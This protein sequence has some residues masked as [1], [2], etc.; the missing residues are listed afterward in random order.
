MTQKPRGKVPNVLIRCILRLVVR[1]GFETICRYVALCN[2]ILIFHLVAP[3][4][5]AEDAYADA[6]VPVSQVL[7]DDMKK[8]NVIRAGVP[9]GCERL[10]LIK[11]SYM[12]FDGSIHGGGEIMAMDAAAENVLR[13]FAKLHDIRF[14][15]AKAKL[16]NAYDGNDD[17]SMA[18]N[19]TSAFN[20]RNVAGSSSLSLHAYGLAIDLNPI[21]NP[22]AQR[23]GA[24]LTFS[25]PAGIAYA[26]RLND[27]PGKNVRLGMAEAVIDVFAD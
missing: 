23:S 6:I 9:V 12:G 3:A 19:N 16:V 2:A 20:A 11:F 5:R 4:A 13:I 26:N 17:A 15:I 21:Q 8:H 7:C 18:D 22:F 24:K 1:L 25:P 14:P 27:R 10:S